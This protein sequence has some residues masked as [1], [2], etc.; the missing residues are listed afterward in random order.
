MSVLAVIVTLAAL[1]FLEK[2]IHQHLHGL[3]YLATGHQDAA[4]MMYALPLLPGVALHELSHWVMAKLLGVKTASIT[5]L[6]KRQRDGHIR[7]GSVVVQQTDIVR[8]SLIGVAPLLVG[9]LVVLAIGYFVLGVGDLGKA[10]QTGDAGA[11]LPALAALLRAPDM[12]IW[13]Y[14]LFAIANAMLPSPSD[15]ETWPPVILFLAVVVLAAYLLGFSRYLFELAPYV[16]TGVRWLAVTFAL[17]L[18]ADLPFVVLIAVAEWMLGTIRGQRVFYYKP[19]EKRKR[20]DKGA[21]S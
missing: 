3:M 7:L 1:A 18:I 21:R 12:W 16:M 9:S 10:L 20:G 5:L 17:T 19:G 2:W 13:M 11:I 4:L 8:S 15:R 6:P 14:L